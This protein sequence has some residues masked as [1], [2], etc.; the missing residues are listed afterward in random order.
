MRF[1]QCVRTAALIALA[2]PT[3][4]AAQVGR[5]EGQVTETNGSP[6]AR[7]TVVLVGTGFRTESDGSG[8]FT[9][10]RVPP[11]RYELRVARLGLAPVS[12]VVEVTAGRTADVRMEMHVAPL[13]L[14]ALT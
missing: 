13:A 9:F 4:V 5:I 11:G 2:A 10:A 12:R 8:R 3:P 7:A 14:D 6:V 1:G